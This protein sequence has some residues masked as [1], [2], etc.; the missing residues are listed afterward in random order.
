VFGLCWKLKAGSRAWQSLRLALCWIEFAGRHCLRFRNQPTAS[1]LL[2]PSSDDW[3]AEIVLITQDADARRI[4]DEQ[5][6]TVGG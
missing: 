3:F 1:L 6:T 4:E 2:I 5:R